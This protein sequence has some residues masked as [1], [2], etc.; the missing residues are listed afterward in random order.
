MR[1]IKLARGI[2]KNGTDLFLFIQNEVMIIK[3][4]FTSVQE[5]GILVDILP[6]N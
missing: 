4:M 3:N 1:D 6:V 2:G 5:S